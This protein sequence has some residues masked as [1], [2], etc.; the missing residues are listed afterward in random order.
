MRRILK[1]TVSRDAIAAAFSTK[2]FIEAASEE[3]AA[4]GASISD[5]AEFD[6][7][8]RREPD[9]ALRLALSSFNPWR[10]N[11]LAMLDLLPAA[12]N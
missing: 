8:A 7:L 1:S 3:V 12:Q 6:A 9:R 5:A 11:R 10:M 4:I 2:A